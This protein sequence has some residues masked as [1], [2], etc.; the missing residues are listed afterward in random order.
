MGTRSF[1][2]HPTDTDSPRG[3]SALEGAGLYTTS[4]FLHEKGIPASVVVALYLGKMA[5]V[6]F[7]K[8]KIMFRGATC[9]MTHH[10]SKEL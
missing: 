6:D 7:G 1:H 9:E 3:E 2:A 10:A 8:F 5:D 4:Y